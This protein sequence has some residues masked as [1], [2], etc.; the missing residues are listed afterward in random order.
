MAFE[1]YGVAEIDPHFRAF[2]DA[3]FPGVHHVHATL[4]DQVNGC[5]C[6]L[7]PSNV[8][9]GCGEES[10]DLSVLGT[11]CDPYSRQRPKRFV[12]GSVKSHQDYLT[13]FRD[14]LDFLTRFEP[15]TAIME[16]VA[17][18]TMVYSSSEE[19]TPKKRPELGCGGG[20]PMNHWSVELAIGSHRLRL[21]LRHSS[22]LVIFNNIVLKDK[23]MMCQSIC[24]IF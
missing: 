9:C 19:D 20:G 2:I 15:H 18:F 5:P 13:T 12:T 17:G 6:L 7:H 3:N 22:N 21:R 24:G 14:T 4:E 23:I 10:P 1:C 8:T 11:A 16:Q